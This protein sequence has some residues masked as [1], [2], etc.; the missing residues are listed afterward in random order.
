[1][2]SWR[3][4]LVAQ[5]LVLLALFS[6]HV[7]AQQQ[8]ASAASEVRASYEKSEYQIP[9]RDGVKLFTVVYSP[10]DK[11]KKYPILLNRTPYGVGPYGPDAYK[12]SLGPSP[13]F[14]KEG[15]IFVYQDVR[16]RYMSEGEFVNMRPHKE[17]KSGP[18]D[19]DEST[20][21]YDTID[22]L[23]KNV[24]NNNGRVGMWGISYPG[25]YV[26]VGMIDAHP[27]LKAASPQA[28]IADWFI[29]DD[30]HHNGAFFLPHAF[31]FLATFGR[32]RPRPTTETP[33]RFQH[34]T[35]DGYKFFLELGPLQNA[36]RKYFKGD[37]A[38]WNEMMEHPNYDDFWKARNTLPHLKNIRPAVMT[39]GGWF[40]AEDLYGALHTYKATEKQ[41]PDAYNILVMGPWYHGGW[42]RSD[43]DSLGAIQFGSKTAEFYRNEIELPFFNCFL[44][45][46]CDRKLP[47]A[48]VFETG[49]NRWRTYTEWPPRAAQPRAIYLRENGKLSFDP[50]AN[51]RDAFDEYVSDPSKPVPYI[52]G[53]AIG[54]TREY[55][56]EDQRFAARRPDVL[57]Y[58]TEPLAQDLT[59]AGPVKVT[60]YVS[61]TGTDADYVVKLID[62][63]P[64]D[65][66]DPE[67]NPTGVRMGGYQM[68]VRGE[69]FRARFRNSFE[70][71]EPLRPGEVTKIEFVMPDINHAFLKG[72][73]IMVQVQS[74][75]FPLVDRNPQKFVPNIY[76]ASESDFQKAIQRVHRSRAHA[77]HI[78]LNVMP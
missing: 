52:N 35:P 45:D 5:I 16:G 38:F 24:P 2:R 15:Y 40:D 59:A 26:A 4:A 65:A 21:T 47:E 72:H 30:F 32:P 39:V 56:V 76:K 73:R 14:M 51:E 10:R 54:M 25:F 33:P 61:S 68:L 63:F 22:W 34:G 44:K 29:G 71:P 49:S 27:A 55:M 50:P 77:S 11:S 6:V 64:D 36:D 53:I 41:S 23:I 62:V 31:N 13:L 1:M 75:W 58:Q 28:P 46:K 60:L 20:D 12:T 3:N 18:T 17:Q 19:T 48:Y 74:T 67:P 66:P 78:T 42:A 37:V 70:R 69:P 43:G 8:A 57:V 7:T 9:M